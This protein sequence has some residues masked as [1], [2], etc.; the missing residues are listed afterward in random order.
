MRNLLRFGGLI[1]TAGAMSMPAS[2]WA[3]EANSGSAEIVVT[4][5]KR[6]QSAQEV[7]I[8]LTALSGETIERQGITSI[9][10]LGNS[11]AGVNIAAANPVPH[12]HHRR[13]CGS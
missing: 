3:D 13:G 10:E 11:V 6:E 4:A 7:P 2:A 9:Q 12:V 8:S 5:Q 1:A